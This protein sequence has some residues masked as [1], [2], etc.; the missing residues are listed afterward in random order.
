MTKLAMCWNILRG[1]PVGYRLTIIG[2]GMTGMRNARVV[3]CRF[4]SGTEEGS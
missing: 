2:R 3:E 1:R 4:V